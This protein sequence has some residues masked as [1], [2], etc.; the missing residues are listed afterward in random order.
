MTNSHPKADK[1]ARVTLNKDKCKLSVNVVKFLGH[2]VNRDGMKADPGKT[3][4]IA[5]TEPSQ[6]VSELRRFM[7][8]YG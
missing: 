6:N 2:I 1:A 3:L 7:H 4:A 5:N 8:G